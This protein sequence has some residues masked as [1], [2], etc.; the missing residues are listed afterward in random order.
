MK[1]AKITLYLPRA[2]RNAA[3]RTGGIDPTKKAVLKVP[4]VAASFRRRRVIPI[5]SAECYAADYDDPARVLERREFVGFGCGACQH[6]QRKPDR[7]GYHCDLGIGLWPDGT[8]KT[9]RRFIRHKRK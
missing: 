5:R 3:H 9:C 8:N 7:S 1:S 6:H 4:A 2:G